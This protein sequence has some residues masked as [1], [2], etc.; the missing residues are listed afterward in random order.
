MLVHELVGLGV[1]NA[2]ARRPVVDPDWIERVLRRANRRLGRNLGRIAWVGSPA[3][4]IRRSAELMLD[5]WTVDDE[6]PLSPPE[7]FWSRVD[8][9]A[10]RRL[11]LLA[12][13]DRH[14][15]VSER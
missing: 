15:W 13:I 3:A 12:T 2:F 6:S 5:G 8:G 10:V 14:F 11:D 4:Y 1:R 7:R 9:R